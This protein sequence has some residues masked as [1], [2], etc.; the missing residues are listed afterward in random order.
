MT[1]SLIPWIILAIT[2]LAD[3]YGFS[4][5]KTAFQSNSLKTKNLAYTIY[6]SLT[7]FAI[8]YFACSILF[9]FRENST[10]TTRFFTGIFMGIFVSKLILLLFLLVEDISRLIIHGY[11][12]IFQTNQK[13]NTSRRQFLDTAF[14]GIASLP[15]FAFIH[16]MF[17]TAYD[18]QLRRINVPIVGL[19][20]ALIGLT[21]AQISDIHSGSFSETEPIREAVKTINKLNPDIFVFTGDLVNNKAKEFTPYI[22]IFKD[23]RAKYGQYSILGNHDYGEY[24]EWDREDLKTEN[25]NTLKQYHRDTNWDLICNENR[26]LDIKGEKLALIGVENWGA[27]MHFKKY[28]NLNQAYFGTE[29]I[30]TKVLLSHDPSHWDAQV[31]K[32]F[33]DI[34]LTL[35]GHTHGMQFGIDTKWIKFSPVQ[36]FYE[37]WAG[38]YTKDNQHIYVNRGF[39]FLGYPG[40]VGIRPEIS[41]LT[42]VK[43]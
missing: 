35:S 12:L 39:G 19:P 43:G 24:V 29:S 26:I 40:R 1:R 31:R 38:L 4:A 9:N 36:W 20:D 17:K 21:I 41:L 15:F 13:L 34:Q 42:L 7:V 23:I 30:E 37:Q 16:G 11:N 27:K 5:V 22:D 28:G 14:L 3:F 6:W 33:K 8:I 10:P 25:F 2:L 32:G 18:Y